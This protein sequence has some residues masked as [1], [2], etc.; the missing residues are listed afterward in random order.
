VD[1]GRGIGGWQMATAR[2]IGRQP[3]QLAAIKGIAEI[4]GHGLFKRHFNNKVKAFDGA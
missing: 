1:A 3:Q 4:V 2:G